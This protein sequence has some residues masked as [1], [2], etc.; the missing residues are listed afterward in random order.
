M[1]LLWPMAQHYGVTHDNL[2]AELHQIRRLLTTK[3][4]QGH[5]VGTTQ[6][7]LAL[8]QPYKDSFCDLNKLLCI[9][10][11]VP[12]TSAACERSFSCLARVKNYLRNS[13]G[14]SRNSDLALLSINAASTRSLDA[15]AIVDAF[16]VNHNNRR[17]VLL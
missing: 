14:D 8:L 17:I 16:A 15:D 10:L 9:S 3:G 13:S 11:T 2:T 5:S 12:V 7:F 1:T 6:E 4:P